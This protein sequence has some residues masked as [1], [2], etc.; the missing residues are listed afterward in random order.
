MSN[1][2]TKSKT[3]IL[4]YGAYKTK[5]NSF[6]NLMIR[7]ETLIAAIQYFSYAK[8]GSPYMAVGRNLAYTKSEFFRE[9]VSSCATNCREPNKTIKKTKRIL[10]FN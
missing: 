6:V 4:G 9:G 5:K 2:F 3:I 7:F 1:H 10:F 8:L